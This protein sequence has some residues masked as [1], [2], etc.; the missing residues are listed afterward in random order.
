MHQSR[1]EQG[2][3]RTSR[4]LLHPDRREALI[5]SELEAD[6]ETAAEWMSGAPVRRRSPGEHGR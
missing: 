3:E 5:F 4:S 2:I 6:T 1:K